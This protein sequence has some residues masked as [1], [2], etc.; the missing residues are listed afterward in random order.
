M[1]GKPKPKVFVKPIFVEGEFQTN[2][3]ICGTINVHY[4]SNVH[5]PLIFK[6]IYFNPISYKLLKKDAKFLGNQ[7]KKTSQMF[8]LI[9]TLST[10]LINQ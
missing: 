6:P 5:K 4:L 7:L 9:Y 10:Y 3:A 2:L 8:R 1:L